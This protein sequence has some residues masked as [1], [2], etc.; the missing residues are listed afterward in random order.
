MLHIGCRGELAALS[1]VWADFGSMTKARQR[2]KTPFVPVC[3]SAKVR[4]SST[5]CVHYDIQ[6]SRLSLLQSSLRRGAARHTKEQSTRCQKSHPPIPHPNRIPL[7]DQREE[8]VTGA[9]GGP[10]PIRPTPMPMARDRSQGQPLFGL[11][12]GPRFVGPVKKGRGK[13]LGR[14]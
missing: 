11:R 14:R 13:R 12:S 8:G 3:S 6:C 9:C 2:H 7:P 1:V 5:R 10:A 4:G